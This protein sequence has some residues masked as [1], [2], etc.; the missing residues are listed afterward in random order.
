[1]RIL[2]VEDEMLIAEDISEI[3]EEMGH[4][5]VGIA[6]NYN[7]AITIAKEKKPHLAL[8][9]IR[10]K[11]DKDGIAVGKSLKD[12][13]NVH[14]VF[15][16]SH[17]DKAI[18]KRAVDANP[19]S[20]LIKPVKEEELFIALQVAEKQ[21]NV[22]NEEYLYIKIGSTKHKFKVSEISHLESD[23]NYTNVY[24]NGEKYITSKVLKNWLDEAEMAM[25]IRI[26]R[27]YAVNSNAITEIGSK[28]LFLN[29]IEVPI[30]RSYKGKIDGI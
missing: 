26:H 30:G 22:K 28:S 21:L 13:F 25:F 11:G 7:K 3:L 23:G 8:L 6:D 12:E 17:S 1:M 24:V 19:L 5:P 20:Y 9:D 4:E 10:I 29:Q 27:G 18:V 15:L 2:I 16:T 14:G